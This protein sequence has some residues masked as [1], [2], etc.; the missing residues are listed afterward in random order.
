MST[1]MPG[2][3]LFERSFPGGAGRVS[4][5]NEWNRGEMLPLS[6]L[7][8][9]MSAVAVC[10]STALPKIVCGRMGRGGIAAWRILCLG[11][12]FLVLLRLA[13]SSYNPFIYFRF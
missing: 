13:G 5:L 9:L 8:I 1:E 6:G 10:Y 7:F 3:V 2:V 4:P 11:L 12:L